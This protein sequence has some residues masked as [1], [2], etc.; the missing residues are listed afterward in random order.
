MFIT[1]HQTILFQGDSITDC[2]RVYN[3]PTSMGFGYAAMASAW[4]D[5]TY[6]HLNLRFYNRGISGHTVKDLKGRWQADCLDL[7]PDWV[8][9]LIGINDT[10]RRYANNDPTSADEYESN[11]RAILQSAHSAL[12]CRFILLEPFLLQVTPEHEAWRED[13]DAKIHVVRRLAREFNALFVPFDGLFAAVSG[14]R[15][16]AFWAEDGVHP[17]NAG[18]ALMAQAWLNAIG[19]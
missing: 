18:H 15:P 1:A 2:G 12:N 13:L 7:Q 6:P 5:A 19:G 8:S 14:T 17:S 4:L 10:W 11:Y 9:I 16:P 3:D